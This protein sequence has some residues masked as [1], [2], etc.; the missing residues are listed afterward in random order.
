MIPPSLAC[1]DNSSAFTKLGVELALIQAL[2]AHMHTPTSVQQL[3]IPVIIK[4]HDVI[5]LAQTGS[6]K[7]LA[8]GL[9]ILQAVYQ[10][11]QQPHRPEMQGVA[12]L[13]IV[14]TREL[15]AQVTAALL[16]I[17]QALSIRL[18]TL[19]GGVSIESQLADLTQ[20]PQV[21]VATPGRLVDLL[22]QGELHTDG[23]HLNELTHWVLDEADRLLDLGFWPD[24]QRLLEFI[25]L[26]RQTLLFSATMSASLQQQLSQLVNN[27]VQ[28][29][30]AHEANSVVDTIE[31]RLYLVNKGSKAK[32]LQA[33]LLQHQWSQALVFISARDDVDAFAK[34]LVK[35]GLNAAPLHGQQTQSVRNQTLADFKAG[36]LAVL[37]ATDLLARGIH[38]DGLPVVFNLD[39]PQH[40]PVYVHRV[41]RTGRAGLTGL[42]ISLVCHADTAALEAIRRLTT[43]ALPLFSLA[44]FPV[45]DTPSTGTS[46]RAPRDKQANRRTMAK[47]GMSQFKSNKGR[48]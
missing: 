2:P 37:V 22:Q 18:Q 30:R 46:K 26:E 10:A 23:L 7:T 3:A 38:L 4:Q 11:T 39:L 25:P 6:G 43:R 19:C 28:H 16:P 35:A 27:D 31:E 36:K 20:Q 21:L 15:A 29:I 14:P 47:S 48:K 34:K 40:A 9:P 12:A 32:A 41:G 1:D 5:A 13:I 33:L 44:A 24:V 45:T 8:F 17:A 42:A